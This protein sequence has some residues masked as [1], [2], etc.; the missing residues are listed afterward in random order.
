MPGLGWRPDC[1]RSTL[2]RLCPPQ[3]PPPLRNGQ[4]GLKLKHDARG[5]LAMAN[6][7][8]NSNSSQVGVGGWGGGWLWSDLSLVGLRELPGVWRGRPMRRW[9]LTPLFVSSSPGLGLQFYFTFAPAP[10]LDGRY[11]VFGRISDGI[12]VLDAIEAVP[13]DG[14]EGVVACIADCGPVDLE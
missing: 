2:T 6:S 1:N 12:E 9:S 5:V 10:T 3:P 7:G 8:K 4:A 11:V 13:A 14:V